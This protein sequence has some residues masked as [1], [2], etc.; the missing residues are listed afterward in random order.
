M[1]WVERGPG[2]LAFDRP[3]GFRCIV[4][5]SADDCAIGPGTTLLSSQVLTGDRLP[6]DVA[7][8][9]DTTA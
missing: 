9:V 6:T 7:V 4:N 8:W 1:T 2:V 3:G 5:F